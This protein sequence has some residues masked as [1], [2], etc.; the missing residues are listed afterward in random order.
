MCRGCR[1][2][3]SPADA[4]QRGCGERHEAFPTGLG[5]EILFYKATHVPPLR[6]IL[7]IPS[8]TVALELFLALL[9]ILY[10]PAFAQGCVCADDGA[11]FC[12]DVKG[13]Q[14]QI[15]QCLKAHREGGIG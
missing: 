5:V 12:M 7:L 1:N 3:F 15:G 4:S 9:A 11:R 10:V 6:K 2:G 8:I 14:A 13:G